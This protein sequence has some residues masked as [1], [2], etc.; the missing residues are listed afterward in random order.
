MVL[1]RLQQYIIETTKPTVRYT[2]QALDKV[3][4][5][6]Q[7]IITQ[8]NAFDI[9]DKLAL[10]M[11]KIAFKDFGVKLE[12]GG[13]GG[14]RK[15][16]GEG[17]FGG[18]YGEGNAWLI[19]MQPG[20]SE[21]FKR[22]A[23]EKSMKNFLNPNKNPLFRE[24]LEII[25]H[26]VLHADQYINSKTKAFDP[27][28]HGI[29]STFGG[30]MED[31]LKNPL[32]IEPYAQQAAVDMIRKGRSFYIGIFRSYFPKNGYIMKRFFKKYQFYLKI[33]K[34]QGDIQPYNKK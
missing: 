12:M 7:K 20:F 25:S 22:F 15:Y 18:D 32:E 26:E 13:K 21:V 5:K 29:E 23:K 9:D 28:L 27:D 8:T 6:L 19:K 24:L 3:F 14:V 33:L 31:Y 34:T 4:Q 11:L 10:K 17:E 1:M 30:S 16:T 2:R